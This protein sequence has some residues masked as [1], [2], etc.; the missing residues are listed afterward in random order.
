MLMQ[1]KSWPARSAA[2]KASGLHDLMRHSHPRKRHQ[3]T[4][5]CSAPLQTFCCVSQSFK[6]ELEIL[7]F[8]RTVAVMPGSNL[9]ERTWA[10]SFDLFQ[11]MSASERA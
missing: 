10:T 2:L 5:E 4:M 1:P 6:D 8:D 7:N 3:I 9:L 11:R